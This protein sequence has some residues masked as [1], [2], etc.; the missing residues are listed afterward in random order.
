[1]LY[2]K[3]MTLPL[4]P[5]QPTSEK[6]EFRLARD[7]RDGSLIALRHEKEFSPIHYEWVD[8]EKQ[9]ENVSVVHKKSKTV[10]KIEAPEP[11]EAPEDEETEDEETE[12]APVDAK[13]ARLQ[14][15]KD[16]RVWLHGT[17]EEK[18][19]YELLKNA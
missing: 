1:M 6:R 7:K 17:E 3:T 14:E 18:A 10:E 11:V 8:E 16:K 15:L 4:Q 19:E 5:L 12:E 9:I 13:E 2:N